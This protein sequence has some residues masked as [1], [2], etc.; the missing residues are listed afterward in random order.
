MHIFL[1]MVCSHVSTSSSCKLKFNCL[2]MYLVFYMSKFLNQFNFFAPNDPISIHRKK[3]IQINSLMLVY[4]VKITF[5]TYKNFQHDNITCQLK[6]LKIHLTNLFF[7][8][9]FD[10]VHITKDLQLRKTTKI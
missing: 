3:R 10:A 7:L 6:I 1:L 5:N 8:M 2:S 9:R 4:L